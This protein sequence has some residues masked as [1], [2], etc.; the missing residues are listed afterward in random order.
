MALPAHL[1]AALRRHGKS[2]QQEPLEVTMFKWTALAVSTVILVWFGWMINDVRSNARQS[3][4]TINRD[5]PE[6]LD[7]TRAGV[8]TLS[9]V[10]DDIEQLRDLAGAAG[11]PTDK[12]LVVYA[13]QL[14]KTIETE[15][16]DGKMLPDTH[17]FGLSAMAQSTIGSTPPEKV[18][19]WIVG[20]RKKAV[21]LVLTCDSREELLK[22]FCKTKF[23][24]PW[25]IQ[26]GTA[27]PVSLEEW[28]KSRLPP[29]PC[30][31]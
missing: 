5:L 24:A 9:K 30:R 10:S 3:L 11:G 6:I 20:A 17:G 27:K 21:Y 13:K 8:A 12:A 7:K 22:E 23:G 16:K 25:Q 2:I 29:A 31:Q 19:D 1:M 28:L 14:I 15:G 26:I 4:D 18:E